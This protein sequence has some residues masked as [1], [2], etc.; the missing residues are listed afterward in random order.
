MS[1][2]RLQGFRQTEGAGRCW[3]FA[4]TCLTLAMG[5]VRLLL[6]L[7]HWTA[8][9]DAVDFPVHSQPHMQ[10]PPFKEF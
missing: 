7:N 1:G 4:T 10:K 9:R 5:E 8:V 3:H 2:K 6:R